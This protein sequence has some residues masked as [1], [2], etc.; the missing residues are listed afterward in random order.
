L[1]QVSATNEFIK[2]LQSEDDLGLVVRAHIHI[3]HELE[4][5]IKACLP[6]QK[7][8]GRMGYSGRVRLALACGLRPSLKGPLNAIGRLRNDFAHELGTRLVE[9]RI[10]KIYKTFTK[11]DRDA[12]AYAY[13]NIT[14]Q[15]PAQANRSFAARKARDQF[16]IYIVTIWAAV[17]AET[18]ERR[19]VQISVPNSN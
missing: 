17:V 2:S 12:A 16:V 6:N 10:N 15:A 4:Q 1:T 8:L 13:N 19:S 3:E 7:E 14:K 18:M 9:E 5:F 11:H